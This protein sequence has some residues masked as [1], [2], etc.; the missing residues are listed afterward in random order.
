MTSP[1]FPE[2]PKHLKPAQINTQNNENHWIR[3]TRGKNPLQK[4]VTMQTLHQ[5]MWQCS[6]ICL[7]LIHSWIVFSQSSLKLQKIYNLLSNRKK[8]NNREMLK[9]L[10]KLWGPNSRKLSGKHSKFWQPDLTLIDLMFLP[11]FLLICLK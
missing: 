11:L 7:I 10:V 9:I 8:V 4:C 5:L 1:Q 3:E 2:V 6:L